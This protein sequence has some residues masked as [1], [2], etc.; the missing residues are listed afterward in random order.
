MFYIAL[1]ILIGC[2]SP[3]TPKNPSVLFIVID[4]TRQD[5]LLKAD[6]PNIDRLGSEGQMVERAISPSS[7][8]APSVLSMFTGLSVREHG[9]DFP[10]AEVMIENGIE[11]PSLP[12]K[13]PTLAEQ[14]SNAGFKTQGVYANRFLVRDIG[15]S[16]GFMSWEYMRDSE[17]PERTIQL[18]DDWKSSDSNF[19]YVHFIGPHQPLRPLESSIKRHSIKS[20]QLSSK[21]GI[22][23]RHIHRSPSKLSLYKKIYKAVIEETD[24]RIGKIVDEFLKIHPDGRIVITSDH[25][26]MIGEHKEI[27]H[28]RGLYQE[29]IHVPLVLYGDSSR[30]VG[31]LFSLT[32]ITDWVTDSVGLEL[33]WSNPWSEY[34]IGRA[35][36]AI[37]QRDRD[38]ALIHSDGSKGVW[39]VNIDIQDGLFFLGD[40]QQSFVSLNSDPK[41]EQLLLDGPEL[42]EMRVTLE[43]WQSLNP[44]G[45]ADGEVKQTNIDFLDDLRALGYVSSPKD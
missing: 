17:I 4:T 19:L 8:T 28:K 42:D 22:N 12:L 1:G 29:L 11:Y 13:V 21:G 39:D 44:I 14:L 2:S 30:I 24:E 37:S 20:G 35:S 34:A 3:Q 38:I 36:F 9:W 18:M 7:W 16:R 33:E 32:G 25:G 41:E 40:V 45:I 6:T 10:L 26:E 5:L 15:F 43:Q 31:P 23:H 27:G